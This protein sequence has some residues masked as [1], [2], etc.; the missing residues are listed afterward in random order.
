MRFYEMCMCSKG[1]YQYELHLTAKLRK[2][3][4]AM[5]RKDSGKKIRVNSGYLPSKDSV[6]LLRIVSKIFISSKQF[7]LHTTEAFDSPPVLLLK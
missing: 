3:Q 7:D 1:K 6:K 5:S 2:E 4:M